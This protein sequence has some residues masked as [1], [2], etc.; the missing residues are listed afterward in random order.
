MYK[1]ISLNVRGLNGSRKQRQVFLLATS[2]KN[3]IQLFSK[4]L[5]P[6]SILSEDERQNGEAKSYL[7]MG[8]LIAEEL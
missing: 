1:I 2:T 5:I 3:Q 4:K 6:R 7:A 8:C